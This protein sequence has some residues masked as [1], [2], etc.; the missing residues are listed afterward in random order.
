MDSSSPGHRLTVST[1]SNLTFLT[2][3]V[4][5]L[6]VGCSSVAFFL[7]GTA[8]GPKSIFLRF[9]LVSVTATGTVW[10]DF[11]VDVLDFLVSVLLGFFS[12]WNLCSIRRAKDPRLVALS[13]PFPSSSTF[14]RASFTVRLSV[15]KG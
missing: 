9:G 8:A 4:C 2:G 5:G 3:V 14:F 13:P 15:G 11:S 7:K 6:T 1:F 10:L 12:R